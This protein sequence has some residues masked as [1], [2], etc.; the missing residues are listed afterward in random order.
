M[1]QEK[2]FDTGTVTLKYAE[3]PPAG[4]PLVLLHGGGDRWQQ[5]QP[6][7]PGLMAHR[8]VYALDM[9]GHG[10]SGRHVKIEGVGHDLGLGAQEVA[11]LLRAMTSFLD[12][13]E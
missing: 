10:K 11:P 6:L 4:P 9:R 5:F 2:R 13:L 8:H 7:M 3:G 1:L 12:L